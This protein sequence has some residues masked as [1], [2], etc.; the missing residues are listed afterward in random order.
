MKLH[1]RV[2]SVQQERLR[3]AAIGKPYATSHPPLLPGL[4]QCYLMRRMIEPLLLQPVQIPHRPAFLARIDVPVLEH[5][6]TYLLPINPQR[7]DSGRA[8]ANEISH[9]FVTLVGNPDRRE[10]AGPQ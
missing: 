4:L 2:L 9:S 10:L 5:E 7:L 6:G 1:E 8:G 3:W